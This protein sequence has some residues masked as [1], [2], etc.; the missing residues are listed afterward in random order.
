MAPTDC[1]PVIK[2]SRTSRRFA[3]PS[4]LKTS[5]VVEDLATRTDSIFRYQHMSTGRAEPSRAWADVQDKHQAHYRKY[6]VDEGAG[7]AFCLVE[8]PPKEAAAAVHRQAPGLVADDTTEVREG[9]EAFSEAR[10]R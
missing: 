7:A 3:S 4:A 10:S 5:D 9:A 2:V 1:S 6:W 8:A